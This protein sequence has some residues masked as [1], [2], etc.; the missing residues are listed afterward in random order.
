MTKPRRIEWDERATA[1]A[2][3]RAHLP[4][5]V[6]D[7]FAAVREL[8]AG[9]PAPPKLHQARLAS[10]RVRYTLEL[11]RQCYGPGLEARLEA[12]HEL[13]QVLGKVND[14]AS[15]RRLLAKAMNPK[16]PQSQRVQKFLDERGTHLALEFRRHWEVFD[17]PGQLEWWTGY[18]ARH[19]RAAGRR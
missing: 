7:Y 3:A 6:A 14:A 17:A 9:D 10:K 4:R 16:S 1:A 13:Q 18:L 2:N 12:L 8:L 19:T 11:F 15:A 5:L